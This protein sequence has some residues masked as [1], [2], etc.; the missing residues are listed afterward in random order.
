MLPPPWCT[1]P[2]ET[3]VPF[4][5]RKFAVLSDDLNTKSKRDDMKTHRTI[6]ILATLL[7]CNA[8]EALAV[9]RYVNV[10]NPTPA[11]PYLTWPTAANNIQAAIDA[12]SFGDV[13]TATNGVYQ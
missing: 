9:E 11:A 1:S 10:N 12:A 4:C 8:V 3:P 2:S 13:I 6:G 7:V 5:P